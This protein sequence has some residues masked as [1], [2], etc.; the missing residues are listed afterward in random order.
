M[1]ETVAS[2]WR[3]SN[4]PGPVG[5]RRVSCGVR[6]FTNAPDFSITDPHMT[7]GLPGKPAESDAV[8]R[9]RKSLSDGQWEFVSSASG[10]GRGLSCHSLTNG[11]VGDPLGEVT[12]VWSQ[13]RG[14]STTTKPQSPCSPR[15]I[16][17]DGGE[18][19]IVGEATELLA[20]C[21]LSSTRLPTFG[22]FE[23]QT[24]NGL[25]SV[26]DT[27]ADHTPSDQD[28]TLQDVLGAAPVLPRGVNHGQN[29]SFDNE[30]FLPPSAPG[31]PLPGNH[32]SGTSTCSCP[33]TQQFPAECLCGQ[34]ASAVL[35]EEKEV[36]QGGDPTGVTEWLSELDC[37]CSL[38]ERSQPSA[39]P[40]NAQHTGLLDSELLVRLPRDKGIDVTSPDHVY[41]F[42]HSNVTLLLDLDRPTVVVETGSDH[43][44]VSDNDDS[45]LRVEFTLP[46]D[47][48]STSGNSP[49]H[50]CAS[51][52]EV[53]T[54]VMGSFSH[55][56]R[57]QPD[58]DDPVI[59]T[60]EGYP[61]TSQIPSAGHWG[62]SASR[63]PSGMVPEP[64]HPMPRCH[65]SQ[66][67]P[68][69][70]QTLLFVRFSEESP[71]HSLLSGGVTQSVCTRQSSQ[72]CTAG[73]LYGTPSNEGVTR[74]LYGGLTCTKGRRC[75]EEV[76]PVTK[77]QV[78]LGDGSGSDPPSSPAR[79][80]EDQ[81]R[82]R[83]QE[84]QPVGEPVSVRSRV[85]AEGVPGFLMHSTSSVQAD[86]PSHG[87]SLSQGPESRGPA[88]SGQAHPSGFEKRSKNIKSS[89]GGRS[90]VEEQ[91]LSPFVTVRTK[92]RLANLTSQIRES[93]LFEQSVPMPTRIR[94]VRKQ[95]DA[96]TLSDW[97]SHDSVCQGDEDEDRSLPLARCSAEED[98][99]SDTVPFVWCDHYGAENRQETQSAASDTVPFVIPRPKERE[100]GVFPRSSD[101][102]G[103]IP[104]LQMESVASSGE[105]TQ[106]PPLP[107]RESPVDPADNCT[108]SL[109]GGWAGT[110]LPPGV[111][112]AGE[113]SHSVPAPET[114]VLLSPADKVWT[115]LKVAHS[116]HTSGPVELHSAP[117]HPSSLR[118]SLAPVSGEPN[119]QREGCAQN[120]RVSEG[121][122]L[123]DHNSQSEDG[124]KTPRRSPGPMENLLSHTEWQSPLSDSPVAV[125]PCG[126]PVSCGA[127][128]AVEYLYTDAEGC[129]ALIECCFPCR[130]TSYQD[131]TAPS[132]EETVIYDWK[133][134]QSAEVSSE[135]KEN[136]SL[137]DESP[138]L[139]PRLHLLSNRQILRQLRE[140]GEDPGPVTDLT[141]GVYL[142]R[143]HQVQKEARPQRQQAAG[144]SPELAQSLDKFLFPDC[145]ED[146]MAVVQ[147]FD[148]PDPRRRW[149]EGIVKSSF[150]YLLLDPRVTKNLPIRCHTLSPA[151]CLRTFVSSIFYV[152]KGKRSR[153]YCHLYQALTHFKSGN[154]QVNA[155]L[156]HILDIWSSGQGV[157]SL[158][159][160]Q[161]VIPVEAY[162]RE[163]CMVDALSLQVLTNK[164]RGDYYGV[165]ATW[166]LRRRR[167]LG[168]H[169]LRRAMEIFLAE[170]ERQLRPA[171]V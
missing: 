31:A 112:G 33:G 96:G 82:L 151:E 74:S 159:C 156:K 5:F 51:G 109:A 132:S 8:S 29:T 27:V 122:R 23:E 86:Q 114:T 103:D 43:P 37:T 30:S 90:L 157:I 131:L 118:L 46:E 87:A 143:L 142:L 71:G 81:S 76:M 94:R 58:W 24:W 55:V 135:D 12:S 41:E 105:E 60:D 152:G 165:A 95:Q 110:E 53:F 127:G 166:P 113:G 22:K 108:E 68:D 42:S 117:G 104:S 150:N 133:A 64:P 50:S 100:A 32:G 119:A 89:K 62:A 111:S 97:F 130:D 88:R 39:P 171:D 115:R 126:H 40:L 134:Y 15:S 136:L 47:D 170:G 158:H 101:V 78:M 17:G 102:A 84:Y 85:K 137:S 145:S 49:Y 141:R 52:Y 153:P 139:S 161:N 147:Q 154:Q 75:Q 4:S 25:V 129:A 54:S 34:Q 61:S 99:A 6:S 45:P 35:Q 38:T 13:P 20:S 16:L 57:P 3:G 69:S 72:P 14:Q 163:A 124:T 116:S 121:S 63:C 11:S 56:C 123:E 66:D 2:K 7:S 44:L 149:R 18:E 65:A 28:L 10:T 164:K 125:S 92:N 120:C 9:T 148:Q 144:Y 168:V 36:F 70:R 83:G 67:C 48:G 155:K 169:M 93:L 59:P 167:R 107:P 106:T 19:N 80:T 1:F 98:A 77:D 160:F 128:E 21:V 26:A 162:T 138:K 140:C 79:G 146:E 91:R 73:H